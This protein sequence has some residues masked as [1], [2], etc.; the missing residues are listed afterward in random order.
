MVEQ[1]GAHAAIDY[2][3]SDFTKI[4]KRFDII[5]DAVGKTSKS[6]CRHLL[7][8]G[9]KYVSV[10]GTPKSNPDDLLV[11][12]ELIESGKIHYRD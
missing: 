12:K 11:L 2:T 9:G 5:F 1:L 4:D 10:T 7:N 6:K 3:Q 8:I